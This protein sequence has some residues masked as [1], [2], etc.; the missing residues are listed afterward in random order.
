MLL[1]HVV[2]HYNQQYFCDYR[3][4]IGIMKAAESIAVDFSWLG[5]V[6]VFYF[7][8]RCLTHNT[9]RLP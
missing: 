3:G 6:S 4:I 1:A 2:V 7:C 5:S 8:F 9:I